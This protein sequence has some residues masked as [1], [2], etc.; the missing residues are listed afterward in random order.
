M[1]GA[2]GRSAKMASRDVVHKWH[3]MFGTTHA[4]PQ[5]RADCEHLQCHIEAIEDEQPRAIPGGLPSASGYRL[6]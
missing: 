5:C 2:P 6:L 3:K 4:C 1:T